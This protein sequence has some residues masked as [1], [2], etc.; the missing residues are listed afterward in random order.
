MRHLKR[1]AFV[2]CVIALLWPNGNRS[3]AAFGTITSACDA[4]QP[5]LGVKVIV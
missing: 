5:Q 2:V 3:S 1:L 4:R